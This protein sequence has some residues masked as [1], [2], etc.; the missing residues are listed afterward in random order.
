[1]YYFYMAFLCV[2]TIVGGNYQSHIRR[3]GVLRSF[4][5]VKMA[6]GEITEEMQDK[7]VADQ[8]K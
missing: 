3:S 2:T 5:K 7:A 6:G 1:M 8:A 4:E